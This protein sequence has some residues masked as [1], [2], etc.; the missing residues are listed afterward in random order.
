MDIL[1]SFIRR[2][3]SS[4]GLYV[5]GIIIQQSGEVEVPWVHK[6]Y[7][8]LHYLQN[9]EKVYHKVMVEAT[10]LTSVV[11]SHA[12]RSVHQG[13]PRS[14]PSNYY[15]CSTLHLSDIRFMDLADLVTLIGEM[16]CEHVDLLRVS[17]ILCRENP[18]PIL[19]KYKRILH[20]RIRAYSCKNVQPWKFFWLCITTKEPR[21]PE[22]VQY[23]PFIDV[24]E[25]VPVE[26]L[27]RWMLSGRLLSESPG[28]LKGRQV[29]DSIEITSTSF[30]S[31]EYTTPR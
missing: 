9:L 23:V 7:S 21:T 5:C 19:R 30:K 3:D 6:V 4:V 2:S 14:L 27:L 18:P 24:Q 28:G 22:I 17:W 11:P 16:N 25:I 29:C 10:L 13:I 15:R 8:K 31:D 1:M 26:N 20:T 12:L